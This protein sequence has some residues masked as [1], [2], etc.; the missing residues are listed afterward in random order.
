MAGVKKWQKT[1]Q[2]FLCVWRWYRSSQIRFSC[3]L[4]RLMGMNENETD[5][6]VVF[7]STITECPGIV[8]LLVAWRDRGVVN[9]TG[10]QK[11]FRV[12]KTWLHSLHRIKFLHCQLYSFELK[13]CIFHVSGV[14]N[15]I[16]HLFLHFKSQNC[17]SL[18]VKSSF[19][20]N[21]DLCDRLKYSRNILIISQA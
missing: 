19:S 6:P 20:R 2:H 4:C 3:R 13:N 11:S 7:F 8:V 18:Y 17:N 1:R 12:V 10:S 14:N 9:I 16:S 21:L 5:V 15:L